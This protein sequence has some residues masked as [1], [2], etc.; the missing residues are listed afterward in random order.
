MNNKSVRGSSRCA[1]IY[2]TVIGAAHAGLARLSVFGLLAVVAVVLSASVANA[3]CVSIVTYGGSGNGTT[4]NSPALASA[5]AALTSTGGCIAFPAGRYK[6]NTA[7]TFNYPVNAPPVFPLYS[8]SLV[9]A[10][11]D[12]TVLYFAASNGIIINANNDQQTIHVSDLTFSTGSAG[13][14][15][16]LTLN[17]SLPNGGYGIQSSDIDRATFR[18]DDDGGVTDYWSNGVNVVGQQDI[19]FD[20]DTFIG[21]HTGADGNGIN[22]SG[23][24]VSPGIVYN[25]SKCGFFST[26]NGLAITTL[27]QGV[28]VTQ[29]NFTNGETG[30]NALAGGTGLTQL[31]VTG[32]NQFNTTGTQIWLQQPTH[33]LIINGNL[34]FVLTGQTGIWLD[35]TGGW[36]T[37]VN[38]VFAGETAPTS[39]PLTTGILVS[40]SNPST[41]VTGNSFNTFSTGVNLTGTSGW[42]VQANIYNPVNN[43]VTNIGSNSVGVVTR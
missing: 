31:S 42:N 12:N 32:G 1:S 39:P 20:G 11:V 30:I 33:G 29:S 27:I 7:V 26:G 22:L 3:Q 2:S 23:T 37:I 41:V 34:F 38:N 10:G 16:A 17:N 9:G 5:Y 8:V 15:S 36:E 24:S 4:N 18:G 21:D 13:G 19:N 25:I 40:G 28:T 14:Y 35:S 6:F 43:Q